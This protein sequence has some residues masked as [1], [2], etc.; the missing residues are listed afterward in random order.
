MTRIVKLILLVALVLL[1]ALVVTPW[2]LDLVAPPAPGV[3]RAWA[4]FIPLII[5]AVSAIAKAKKKK[6][7][8]GFADN[9]PVDGRD[10]DSGESV[11][12]GGFD[13]GKAAPWLAGAGGLAVGSMLGRSGG[14]NSGSQDGPLSQLLEF[15]NRRMLAAEPLNQSGLAMAS[16]MMPSYMK[17]PGS[18]IDTWL[19]NHQTANTQALVDRDLPGA[20]QD[21]NV[22]VYRYRG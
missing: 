21:G 7:Q 2:L 10:P 3:D 6:T 22:P 4:Q 16:S 15:Q 5:S 9:A 14:S 11:G 18:A 13:W 20:T 19:D 8:M 1:D 12:G 17:T